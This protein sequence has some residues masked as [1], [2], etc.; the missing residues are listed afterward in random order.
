MKSP[1]SYVLTSPDG[2]IQEIQLLDSHRARCL[3]VIEDIPPHFAGFHMD[4]DALSFNIKSALAQLGVDGRA[5]EYALE[6]DRGRASVQVELHARGHLG[7]RMLFLL[8]SGLAYIGKLFVQDDRRYVRDPDDLQRMAK[9]ADALGI[10]LFSLGRI[11][12]NELCL[13]NVGGR[14]VARLPL[15]QGALQFTSDIEE[16]LPRI[17]SALRDRSPSLRRE[18]SAKQKLDPHAK[19]L[20]SE[21]K[22]LL[23]ATAP[24]HVR[25]LFARVVQGELPTGYRHTSASILEPTT[26]SSGNIYELFGDSDREI[27]SIPLEFFML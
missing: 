4:S 11:E 6:E 12:R 2:A 3:V 15:C 20:P 24:L 26:A 13:D 5:T 1:P 21:H 25:T 14:V 19:R 8:A 23:V 7:R 16:E 9:Q 17:A 10:P 18:L 27:E 22:M